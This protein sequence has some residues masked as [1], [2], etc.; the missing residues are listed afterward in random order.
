MPVAMVK[1]TARLAKRENRTISELVREALRQYKTNGGRKDQTDLARIASI[2]AEAKRKPMTEK[3]LRA[4]EKRL[5]EYGAR[6][7][8]K[9]GIKERDI[10]RIIHES[11]AR[12]TAS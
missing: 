7:S 12:R 4:E 6:Q 2:L 1:A 11:R 3:D 9:L 5:M 8:K 10:V